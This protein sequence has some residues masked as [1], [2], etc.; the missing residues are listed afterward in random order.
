MVSSQKS[1]QISKN[2]RTEFN[3]VELV[4]PC[5]SSISKT[6]YQ[7]LIKTICATSLS[8]LNLLFHLSVLS[9][10][11]FYFVSTESNCEFERQISFLRISLRF[12][13]FFYDSS[14][15]ISIWS[16]PS[17]LGRCPAG[18]HSANWCCVKKRVRN[19]FL[20]LSRTVLGSMSRDVLE[21]NQDRCERDF[22]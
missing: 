12:I 2:W 14:F 10:C 1:T 21:F 22:C 7:C 19:E 9:V 5:V 17:L 18:R 15:F 20:R 8:S 3:T 16:R 11:F 6:G 4:C 13:F